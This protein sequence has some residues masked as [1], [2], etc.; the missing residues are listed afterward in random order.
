MVK[1]KSYDLVFMD[2]MM[3]EMDGIEAT[4]IIRAWEAELEAQGVVR[5]AV[6][7]IALTANAVMGMR[8]MF[9]EKGFSDF[10]AKPIDISKMDEILNRWIPKEK[11]EVRIVGSGD[12]GS[13]IGDQ[14]IGSNE[15]LLIP[16]VDTAKGIAMTGGTVAAYK[17]VLSMFRA[18]VQERLPLLNKVAADALPAFITQV[19]ALKSAS[20]SLGAAEV[21]TRAAGLEAAGKTGNIAFIQ[22]NLSGFT[23]QLA[24]LIE[25][26]AAAL[27][28][29]AASDAPPSGSD[30]PSPPISEL[31]D[32]AEALRSQNAADIDRL[33][34]ELGQKPLDAET[35][36]TVDMISDTILIA[37][38]D[39]ALEIIGGLLNGI[40]EKQK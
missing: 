4:A 32:L 33:L 36:K 6:P 35:R 13:G 1:R 5:F 22:E 11:R 23:R 14:V 17:Q 12:Q 27:N 15:P 8:E 9:I 21:S 18:D 26:I 37:E 34:D 40:G 10:L 30:A 28:K 31:N 2:H 25:E 38:F 39:K 3:P 29:D 7:I 24:E 19:H 20:A 16:G